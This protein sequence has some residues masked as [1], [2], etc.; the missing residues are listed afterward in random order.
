MEVVAAS[1]VKQEEEE[2]VAKEDP[3][4]TNTSDKAEP[5]E[6]KKS[7]A[8]TSTGAGTA[9]EQIES[10]TTKAKKPSY[11]SRE[12][13]LKL[14]TQRDVLDPTEV[15]DD[16]VDPIERTVRAIVPIP[17]YYYWDICNTDADIK[18]IP[19]TI[20]LWHSA[21]YSC[22]V[23][24]QWTTKNVGL[25][26]ASALGLTSSRFHEVIDQMSPQELDESRQQVKERRE[27]E[28]QQ[29]GEDVI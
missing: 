28:Q 1:E 10:T 7:N 6:P 3:L 4:S 13:L 16:M 27:R 9:A 25:P 11:S 26:I 23:I 24:G 21:I 19:K 29:P 12:E 8:C 14:V 20:Q 15:Q 2:P 22:N 17:K 18:E 5:E